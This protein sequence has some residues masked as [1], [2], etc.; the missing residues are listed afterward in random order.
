[1][2]QYTELSNTLAGMYYNLNDIVDL[3]IRSGLQPQRFILMGSSGT[4]FTLMIRQLELQG[5]V[6]KLVKEAL[7]DYP[8]NKVLADAIDGARMPGNFKSVYAGEPPAKMDNTT[9]RQYEKITQAQS[10]LLP[11]SF[12]EKGL[13]AARSVARIVTPSGLGSGFLISPD[14]L[15]LTNN[16]VID[17][18][19]QPGKLK[20]QF[21]YQ[22]TIKELPDQYEEFEIDHT[23]FHT[24]IPDDWTIVKLKGN[25]AEKY[26]FLQL[27]DVSI[28]E[29]SFVNIIQHPGGEYKQIALYHNLVT[30]K[31]DNIVQYLTD[32]LPGSSGSPVFNSQW[33]V[34]ALHHSGG[35][36]PVKD[37]SKV[38]RNEGININKI[39]TQLRTLTLIP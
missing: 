30:F 4:I 22:K 2:W 23:I 15:L 26:G 7:K 17:T 29:N 11:I 12:L 16:H 33:D 6:D 10:T 28:E 21:N 32:T 36:F 3:I 13:I 5:N 31:D 18:T 9:E 25:P 20:A 38:L 8:G 37:G 14:N 1:M 35:W 39:I 19:P 27:K 24:S 34:V